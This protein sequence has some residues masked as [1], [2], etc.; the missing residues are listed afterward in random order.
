MENNSTHKT[1][2]CGSSPQWPISSVVPEELPLRE[3]LAGHEANRLFPT[4]FKLKNH[5]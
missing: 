5:R 4:D 1:G 3:L 2:V